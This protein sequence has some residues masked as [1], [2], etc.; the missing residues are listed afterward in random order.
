MA[1][2]KSYEFKGTT[3]ASAYW[4]IIDYDFKP[5]GEFGQVTVAVYADE[6]ARTAD[7]ANN[8]LT[9]FQFMSPASGGGTGDLLPDFSTVMTNLDGTTVGARDYLYTVLKDTDTLDGATDV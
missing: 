6:A 8:I 7:G 9:T 5:E 3:H 2:Q 4:R 1:L